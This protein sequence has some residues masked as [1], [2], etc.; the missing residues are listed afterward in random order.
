MRA[1]DFSSSMTGKLTPI[2]N[3]TP[4]A[5][6]AFTPDPLPPKWEWPQDLWPLLME[7]RN[8]LSS[9]D[10]TGKHL[11]NPEILLWPLQNRESQL[12]SKLE[13]TITDPTE[14][15]IFEVDPRDSVSESDPNN[16]LREVFNYRRALRLRLDGRL[17]LPLSK[18]LI[19]ELHDVLMR[20]VRG[21]DQNPGEFRTMQNRIGRPARYVPP[22]MQ[23]LDKCL[24]DFESYLHLTNDG[25][26][27]LVRS[28][29]A[30]Y[31]FEAIHPFG[32]GN[33]RVGRLLLSLTI[34]E[35]C[36]LSSQWLYM[37]AYFERR[38]R[39]Y[40]DLMF[41]V[42]THGS[43]DLWMRFCLEGV[44]YQARDA[45]KR[46]DKLLALHRDFHARLK[47]G[48]VRLSGIV[49]GLFANPV[50][51]VL[52]VKHNFGVTH[53][54]AHADLKKLQTLGIL[55]QLKSLG[56][57]AYYCSEIY[58]ITFDDLD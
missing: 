48:S 24:N 44:I 15:A 38:R 27:P 52:D 43:W 51:R 49:D 28:F 58:D 2:I 29:L 36:N 9:L 40:M 30:H 10:G 13:G 1:D 45:E 39:E 47:K 4:D 50:I 5:P 46:C 53:P 17:D 21:S 7:A 32:D 34:A 23:D 55:K 42:S 12:S 25:F 54:T 11:T 18:R 6:I 22:P 16:A 35:W 57:I 26:D 56:N 31:Q 33:G 14:Q 41:A 3:S 37:S 8:C 19:R 20:G